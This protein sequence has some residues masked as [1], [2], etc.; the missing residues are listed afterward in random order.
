MQRAPAY[1]HGPPGRAGESVYTRVHAEPRWCVVGGRCSCP[2]EAAAARLLSRACARRIAR[3][4]AGGA[5]RRRRRCGGRG[6]GKV[7]GHG[8]F[9][10]G[11]DWTGVMGV[12]VCFL[13]VVRR[14]SFLWSCA[15]RL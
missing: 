2:P 1:G 7:R 6:E 13:H 4:S 8:L 12:G 5:A 15:L 14:G 11:A 10:G 3:P 9:G